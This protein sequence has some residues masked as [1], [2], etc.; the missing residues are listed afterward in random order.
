MFAIY[1]TEKTLNQ[2]TQEI[3]EIKKE[4]LEIGEMRPGSLSYQYKVPEKKAAPYW[5]LSYTHKMKRGVAL[6]HLMNFSDF[7]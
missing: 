7:R 1:M 5:Q 3:Q 2:I 6:L 4:L